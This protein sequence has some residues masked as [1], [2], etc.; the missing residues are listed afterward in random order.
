[1]FKKNCLIKWP[2]KEEGY[3]QI[4]KKLFTWFMNVP[5]VLF[6]FPFEV[7]KWCKGRWLTPL[8]LF[9]EKVTF[10]VVGHQPQSFITCV[11]GEPGTTAW[12]DQNHAT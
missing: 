8:G 10:S 12:L 1:M 7:K 6:R 9:Y 4:P 11:D 5:Y 2:T 3:Q